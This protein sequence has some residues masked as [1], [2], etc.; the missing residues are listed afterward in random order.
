MSQ[1]GEA[2]FE[3]LKAP[4]ARQALII[5]TEIKDCLDRAKNEKKLLDLQKWN[6]SVKSM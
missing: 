4:S 5:L 1:G 3:C 6:Q 2:K